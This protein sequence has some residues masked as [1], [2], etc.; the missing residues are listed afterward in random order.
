MSTYSFRLFF[1]LIIFI[2]V[3]LLGGIGFIFAEKLSIL[4]SLYFTVITIATV[5]YGD[6]HPITPMGRLLT[7]I[8]IIFGVGSFLGVIANTTEM[9]LNKR[10][11]SLRI[12][13]LQ[14][15][16]GSFFGE[17]GNELLD[18]LVNAEFASPKNQQGK[19]VCRNW[20][21]L[22]FTQLLKEMQEFTY[23][24]DPQKV[25]F[26]ILKPMLAKNREHLANLIENPVIIDHES[27]AELIQAIYHLTEELGYRHDPEHTTE[28]DR[29]H[30]ITDT[31]RIFKRL[32]IEWLLYM[33]NLKDTYPYLFS[34]A[35]RTNPFDP[36]K[37]A[38]IE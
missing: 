24:V 14:M 23:H 13:K 37:N 33:K 27:F 3:M 22:K 12:R 38:I 11:T 35:Q 7:I 30:L 28:N 6:I 10:E 17:L 16:L 36:T 34:L 2:L 15:I 31:N 1:Y 21:N 9:L 32:V 8:I 18:Y 29:K 4:D 26:G 20:D 25:D 19:I 5:G